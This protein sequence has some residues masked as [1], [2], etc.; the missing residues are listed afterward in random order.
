MNISYNWLKNYLDLNLPAQEISQLL[1]DTGLEVEGITEVES[2]KGGLKGVVIGEVMS[3]VQHPNADRLSVTTVNVGEDETI[4]IVCGAPNV[5][6]GQKVPVA[7]VGTLLYDGDESFKIKKGKLRGEASLGMICAEDEL[8]LGKGH[9]GIMVLEENAIV[10]TPAAEYFKL[11][12]DIVFEIGLTPNRSDAMGHIGVARDLMTVLNHK[13]NKLQMC[14][15]STKDFKVDNTNGTIAVEVADADLCPRYSGVSIS[16]IK[17]DNSPEWLQNKLKAIGI[18]PTNNV[19]DITNYV[20]HEIGQPLH[21]FDAD[22]IEGNKVVVATVND[23]TKFTT[24]DEQERELSAADLMISDAKKPMCIAGVFGGLES[25]VSEK[26]TSIFLESAYFNPVSVRKTAKRHNLST[27]ASFRFERGC[28]PNSTV[29]ALKRAALLIQEICGGTISSE[30][31]DIYPNKIEHFSVEL[32][33]A[34]MDNLIGEK[35]DR[36]VVKAILINLEIEISKENPDGLSLLVPPFRADV[37]REV[38]VI[39]EILRIYGFNTVAISAKLNTTI[40]HADGV[41]PEDVRNIISDLLSSTG[42]NEA[43]NNSLTKGKYTALIPELDMEQNVEILNPLSQ[44]LNVMRQSLLFSGLENIAYNQNRRNADIKFYEFGKT[45][46]KTEEGNEENQHLQILVSGRKVSENWDTNAGIA[47]FYFIKE[48]VE[49]IL[50]RLGVKK[51]K[52]EAINTH[53]FSDGLMY[54]FKKK[55]MVCFGKLNTKLCKSFGVKSTVY[56]A[57]FNWD[58][59]L[60]LAGYAKIKYQEVSKFPSVRRDLSLLIDKS[61][62]FAELKKIATATDNKILKSVNLFD[63]YEGDKLPNGKKSYALSFIMADE[64]K[65]LTDKYVDKVM[66]KLM[67]SFTDKAGAEIR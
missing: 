9:D 17:V 15:P 20:L 19:V 35:I 33:Y 45:Y 37:Q 63:V 62:S 54:K 60:E 25:G 46:H 64:T 36:E 39:E 14:K 61:V 30:V 65:T 18:M 34:K 13:G 24:L 4:Q 50:S 11:E 2:V 31:I 51:I 67:K 27:D 6:V 7:T 49:H 44:D 59:I 10:G 3:K 1:T 52:S 48:K 43:M 22:K 41:N 57:D 38:D 58:L 29:Y 42:F 66:D 55:R 56:A 40:S 26:T 47:D 8:G 53:G 28:D 5:A 32:T 12:S 23:K 21:P 16:G